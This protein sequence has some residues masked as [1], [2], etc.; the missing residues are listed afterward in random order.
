MSRLSIR[1]LLLLAAG[2]CGGLYILRLRGM[3][4][5]KQLD[6][7]M[8]SIPQVEVPGWM[9]RNPVDSFRNSELSTSN[10]RRQMAVR[11]A[12]RHAWGGYRRHAFGKDE[13]QPV[14][15][16]YNQ[17]WGNWSIT[18]VD[19]L[20]SLQMMGLHDEYAEAK[21]R[22]RLVDFTRSPPNH[23]VPVFEMAIRA[24]GGL[25]GA[26]ELDNDPMFLQKARDVADALLIAF[27]TPTG[28]P[29]Q[30]V[31]LNARKPVFSGDLAIAEGGTVQLE[32]KRLSQLTGDD[33]YRKAGDR[34]GEAIEAG[35]RKYKGLYPAFI[36]TNTGEYDASSVLSVGAY[37]DSFYEYQLKQFLFDRKDTKFKDRYLRS[38][39]AVKERLVAR[40]PTS[41]RLFLGS[42]NYGDSVFVHEMEHLACFYPG[43]LALGAQALDRPRDLVLAEE[44]AYTCYVSYA[45][46]PTGLG[47][48]RFRFAGYK[49]VDAAADDV[50][51]AAGSMGEDVKKDSAGMSGV[52][53]RYILRPE[54]LESLFILFRVTGDPKYQDWGWAIFLAIEKHAKV[55]GGYAAIRNVFAT[56]SHWNLVDSMESFFTAETLKYLYLLFGPSDLLSLDEY[57]LNTEA[58]PLKITK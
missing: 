33:K 38:T 12:M 49:F 51:A 31:D 37:V 58:H 41:G 11:D 43:L 27:D 2:V 32:F 50:G 21:D 14:S 30:Q 46:T 52:D 36:N 26:Y 28:L 24:L 25:L 34:A 40:D 4:Q 53:V 55:D 48:E 39:M 6:R 44:L 23:S 54:T 35:E 18:L 57:V 56:S 10:Y 42:W 9:A 8:Q 13:L 16:T 47:P 17:R 1:R 15:K 3:L 20:D 22:V 5:D 7:L 19:S 45:M 29:A